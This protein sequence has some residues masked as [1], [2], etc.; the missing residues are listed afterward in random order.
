MPDDGARKSLPSQYS[1]IA[2]TVAPVLPV[3]A[4]EQALANRKLV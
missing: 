2:N 4:R 1:G 3:P